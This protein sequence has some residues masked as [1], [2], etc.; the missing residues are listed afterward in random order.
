MS[1]A[2]ERQKARAKE[3]AERNAKR[4][5]AA[6][7]A[8][9][10]HAAPSAPVTAEPADT[11]AIRL[12]CDVSPPLYE[13]FDDWTRPVQ[14]THRFGRGIKSDIMRILLRDFLASEEMQ[15]EVLQKLIA[16]RRK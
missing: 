1:T 16:E 10:G 3:I 11:K 9:Q 13:S 4:R 8:D 6:A 7:A 2:A 14:R 12:T 5:E 15:Q